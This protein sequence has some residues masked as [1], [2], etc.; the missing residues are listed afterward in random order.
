MKKNT[1]YIKLTELWSDG[2]YTE[3]GNIIS[4]ENWSAS[5]IVEFCSY[6]CKYCG[7]KELELLNKFI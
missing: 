6:F 7:F 5:R 1:E 2:N 3:V 4:Q